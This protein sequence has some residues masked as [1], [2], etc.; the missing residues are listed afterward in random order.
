MAAPLFH[1]FFLH[2]TAQNA[3]RQIKKAVW[4]KFHTA[5]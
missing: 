3:Q 5:K 1:L 2:Y 4:E